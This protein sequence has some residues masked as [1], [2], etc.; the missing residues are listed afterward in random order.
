MNHFTD[1]NIHFMIDKWMLNLKRL[2]AF[3]NKKYQIKT[4][5]TGINIDTQISKEC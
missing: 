4:N 1:T 2:F 3:K 5:E